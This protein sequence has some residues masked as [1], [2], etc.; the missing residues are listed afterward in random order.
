MVEKNYGHIVTISNISGLFSIDGLCDYSASK[1]AIFSFEE[2]LRNELISL[3]K[4]GINTTLVCHFYIK[5]KMN[6]DFTNE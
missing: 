1:F 3:G 6:D 4:T 2:S 5:S